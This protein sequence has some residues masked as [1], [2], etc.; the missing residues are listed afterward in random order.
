[1]SIAQT[2]ASRDILAGVFNQLS[3]AQSPLG[4]DGLEP[5]DN[6]LPVPFRLVLA[7][8]PFSMQLRNN[9]LDAD[10]SADQLI[11]VLMRSIGRFPRLRKRSL[12]MRSQRFELGAQPDRIV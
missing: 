7:Q 3:H 12:I 1:M 8:F 10:N 5:R 6:A 4:R 2:F 9:D 11:G